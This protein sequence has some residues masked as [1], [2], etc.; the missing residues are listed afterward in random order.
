M[1]NLRRLFALSVAYLTLADF[2]QNRAP[3]TPMKMQIRE[4][5][6]SDAN[7]ITCILRELGWFDHL[8]S[9]AVETTQQRIASHLRLCRADS[10]HSV[11]VAEN[12][13]GD[14]VGYGAVHWMPTLFLAG[15]EGYVSELFVKESARGQGAGTQ[16]L[17]AMAAEASKRGCSRLVVLNLRNRESYQ[18][19]F[20]KKCGWEE[21]PSAVNFIRRLSS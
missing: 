1:N 8:S 14:V 12:S 19:D 18:R 15:P 10:S 9:E 3:G 4:A 7:S 13:A 20:Y 16:L 6:T 11:Y 2:Y 21:R 17:E 5:Q